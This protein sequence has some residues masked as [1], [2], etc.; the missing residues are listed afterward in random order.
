MKIGEK[1]LYGWIRE[2]FLGYTIIENIVA[3]YFFYV[4]EFMPDLCY[5]IGSHQIVF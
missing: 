3:H 1:D 5:E 2:L 4:G